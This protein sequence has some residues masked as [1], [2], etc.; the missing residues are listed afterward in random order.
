MLPIESQ[1]SVR[2]VVFRRCPV[3]TALKKV[4]GWGLQLYLK[5]DSGQGFSC[6]FYETFENTFFYRTPL[7]ALSECLRKNFPGLSKIL[8]LL[9]ISRY[10]LPWLYLDYT[11]SGVFIVNFEQTDFT[12][13]SDVSIVDIRQVKNSVNSEMPSVKH[14]FITGNNKAE[15]RTKFDVIESWIVIYDG[16]SQNLYSSNLVTG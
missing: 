3:K 10:V 12:H 5:R 9:L 14:L 15:L 13:R 2:E 6:E 11:I 1:L 7:S 4:A 8:F 16:N